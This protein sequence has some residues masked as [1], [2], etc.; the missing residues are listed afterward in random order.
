M[1]E[2][3]R[4]VMVITGVSS[5]LGYDLVDYY[6][7]NAYHVI[8]CSRRKDDRQL[9]HYEHFP[10]DVSLESA[11]NELVQILKSKRGVDVLINNAG[12]S[13]E[14][15]ALMSSA[16]KMRAV[17]ES[18][19]MTC[20][21]ASREIAKLMIKRRN[22]RIIN[23]SS[24]LVPLCLEGSAI[25]SASKSAMEQYG[26][27]LAKEVYR[28]GITV[29]NI[30]LSVVKNTGMANHLAEAAKQEILD[31]TIIKEPIELSD[32]V[33]AIDFFCSPLAAR[34]TAHTLPIG[35]F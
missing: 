34:I 7:K 22:G 33:H 23:I 11:M 24:A 16:S 2:S 12:I 3:E 9:E 8:G 26:R 1:N 20:A 32:L 15:I 30:Q 19:F 4:P 28:L 25:Y 17:L 27:V 14:T 18:N 35:G 5:G 31:R 21:I 10:V 29:N 13:S 6:S